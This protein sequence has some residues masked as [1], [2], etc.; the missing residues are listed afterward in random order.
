MSPTSGRQVARALAAAHRAGIVHRDIKPENLMQRRDGYV[1]V[2]DFGLARVTVTENT[3]AD[4]LQVGTAPGVVVGTSAYM[5]PEQAQGHP[6]GS[7]SDIFSLG[8]TLYELATGKKPFSL[9]AGLAVLHAIIKSHPVP[10]VA[11]RAG[12]SV[13]LRRADRADAREGPGAAARRPRRSSRNSTRC[14][15]ATR[16]RSRARPSSPAPH[17]RPGPRAGRIA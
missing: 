2:L 8:V 9:D 11:P 6:V 12:A 15:A 1:K 3:Q 16:R 7:P 17:G 10:P 13:H 4:T 14:S 5:S